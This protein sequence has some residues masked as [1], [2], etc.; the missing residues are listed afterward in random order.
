MAPLFLHVFL[1]QRKFFA[2]QVTI[3]SRKGRSKRKTEKLLSFSMSFPRISSHFFHSF[4]E[5]RRAQRF[6]SSIGNMDVENETPGLPRELRTNMA[7]TYLQLPLWQWTIYSATTFL[8]KCR[9]VVLKTQIFVS[10]QSFF[11]TRFF[12]PDFSNQI[13]K[14]SKNRGC[15]I[16]G[17]K[18]VHPCCKWLERL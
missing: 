8:E 11:S 13:S 18:G 16:K 9:K 4:L 2:L 10:G 15:R 1:S 6:V 5:N 12:E 17:W 7:W 14:N 3:K